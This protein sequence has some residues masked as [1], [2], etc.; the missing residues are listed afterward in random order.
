M[1]V[2]EQR[3]HASPSPEMGA[4]L[5]DKKP[6]KNLRNTIIY[7]AVGITA[8][9]ALG[10]GAV[11]KYYADDELLVPKLVTGIV[12]NR[13][14]ST[15]VSEA[16]VKKVEDTLL[17]PR[18][19]SS[20][21]VSVP[22]FPDPNFDYRANIIEQAKKKN[23]TIVDNRPALESLENAKTVDQVV[24]IV[25]EYTSQ[26]DVKLEFAK[27]AELRDFGWGIKPIDKNKVDVEDFK[28]G[29]VMLLSSFSYAPVEVIKTS[30]I[31]KINLVDLISP[32]APII[33]I[34]QKKPALSTNP[35]SGTMYASAT[36]L[37]K[38][39]P[40]DFFHE[41]THGIDYREC[42][43]LGMLN[44]PEF[45]KTNPKGFNYGFEQENETGKALQEKYAG[46]H[47]IEDKATNMEDL[48]NGFSIYT[49]KYENKT[50]QKKQAVE[51]ARLEKKVPHITEYIRLVS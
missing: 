1:S 35:V 31:K 32:D 30:G 25:N 17:K 48:F 9:S 41:F 40:S 19:Y 39:N 5:V 29:A 43:F 36:Y 14:C 26:F 47:V 50:L 46:N 34:Y 45:K 13:S 24:T 4:P 51:I 2:I 33:N 6:K 8:V 11:G 23:L 16:D 28:F 21:S 10:T 49:Y 20:F 7:S 3:P 44:D 12:T 15:D 38:L 22:R 42:G 27:S 18:V 37:H